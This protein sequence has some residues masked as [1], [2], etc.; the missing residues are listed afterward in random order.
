MLLQNDE[1][2]AYDE[3]DSADNAF[4]QPENVSR[5]IIYST[6]TLNNTDGSSTDQYHVPDTIRPI[7]FLSDREDSQA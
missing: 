3:Y 4:V 1:E 2:I 5:N 6:A 7:Y